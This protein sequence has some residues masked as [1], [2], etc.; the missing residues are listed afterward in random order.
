MATRKPVKERSPRRHRMK[1]ARPKLVG[2]IA[3]LADLRLASRMKEP[4]DLFELRLDCLVD[5]LDEVEKKMSILRLARWAWANLAAFRDC[6][7][8]AAARS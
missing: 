3:S 5:V 8:P 4:P 1:A 2:V 7:S 6:C